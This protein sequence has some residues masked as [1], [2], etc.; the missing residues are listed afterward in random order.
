M[1]ATISA[2]DSAS[3]DQQV[4]S[5]DQPPS[6]ESI[7]STVVQADNH[8]PEQSLDPS[9]GQSDSTRNTA[10]DN[11]TPLISQAMFYGGKK[12]RTTQSEY[13][14]AIPPWKRRNIRKPSI[15]ND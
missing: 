7:Q 9:V 11:S 15:Y 4:Q 8:P 2:L 3:V 12:R 14:G 5:I 1:Q 13:D 6:V 10:V